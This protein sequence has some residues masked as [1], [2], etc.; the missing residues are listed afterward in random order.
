MTRLPIISL[1]CLLPGVDWASPAQPQEPSEANQTQV[2]STA[3]ESEDRFELFPDEAPNLSD[4]ELRGQGDDP[5]ALNEEGNWVDWLNRKVT[6]SVCGS[7]RWFDSFFGTQNEFETRESTFGRLG[8]GAFWDED[9]GIDPEFRFR[10]KVNFP[11]MDNR[12]QAVMGRGSIDEVLDGEDTS[13]PAEDFFDEESEWLVGFG[14]NLHL[15]SRS[16]LS[17][18]VGTSWSS[19]LDPYVRIRYV[20]QTPTGERG[21]FRL[22]LTPYWQE[23]QGLGY[24]FRPGYDLTLGERFMVRAVMSIKDFEEKLGG[25]SYGLYLNL[26][27]K[28]SPKNALRYKVGLFSQANLEHKPQDVGGSISWRTAVYKELLIIESLVGTSFRRR[29]EELSR[30]PELILGLVFEL[31][32]GR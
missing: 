17:P 29:P 4:A 23:T 25:F 30:D 15:G 6:S 11:N 9:D 13:S 24:I 21:Q 8:V 14:Y 7:S 32:F 16:R 18:S 31:K 2:E 5:C 10:A 19:G 3:Q 12:F 28:V 27:H 1:L 20:F 22:K 26:F